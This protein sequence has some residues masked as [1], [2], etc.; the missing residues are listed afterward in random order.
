[1]VE[2]FQTNGVNYIH[3]KET[4]IDLNIHIDR[5]RKLYEIKESSLKVAAL[6]FGVDGFFRDEKASTFMD[7]NI[8]SKKAGLKEI[9]SLIPGVYTEKLS[10]YDYSGIVQFDLQVKGQVGGQLLLF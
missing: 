6:E 10:Q 9:L 7:V 3:H 8:K 4:T 2:R 5:Q 1:M